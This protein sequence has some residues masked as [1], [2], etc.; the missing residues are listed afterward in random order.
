MMEI[1]FFYDSLFVYNRD[2][3]LR[4]YKKIK[5]L[6]YCYWIIDKGTGKIWGPMR[7]KEFD[8]K[9]ELLNVKAKMWRIY[10][11]KIIRTD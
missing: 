10:E 4:Q 3:F 2:S 5:Q 6:K 1:V 9:C 7:K 11:R 8:K